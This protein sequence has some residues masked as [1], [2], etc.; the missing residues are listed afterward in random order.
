VDTVIVLDRD[1]AIAEATESCR[2]TT[3]RT[4]ERFTGG[5]IERDRNQ[6]YEQQGGW[7]AIVRAVEAL[8]G[9]R[10]DRDPVQ[11]YKSRA[12]ART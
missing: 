10:L 5:R 7:E 8:T 2:E 12:A 11:D 1:G 9:R 4:M 6:G 3:V